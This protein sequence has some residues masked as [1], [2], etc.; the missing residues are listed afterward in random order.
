[1]ETFN[2]CPR[3]NPQGSAMLRVLTAQFGDGYQ[4]AAAD[5]IHNKIETWPLEFSGTGEEIKPIKDFLDAR[6]G[7]EAFSWTP[8]LGETGA[9]R[10][11][12]YTLMPLGADLYNLTVT[13]QQVWKP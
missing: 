11:P 13:L 5:G 7:W 8:P 1:M 10:A 6:G 12:Q 4:Q 3:V 9:Y 2:W